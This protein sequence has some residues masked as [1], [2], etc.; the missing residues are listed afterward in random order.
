MRKQISA[1]AVCAVAVGLVA[2]PNA[3]AVKSDKM[4]FGTV[5]VGE[6]PNPVADSYQGT[7]AVTGNVASNSSCRKY[8]T[9]NFDWVIGA[10]PA[11]DA[12]PP[13]TITGPNGD[14]SA[15]LQRPPV[16]SATASSV[17]LRVTVDQAF[18]KIGGKKKSR[19]E[20]LKGRKFNCLT[21]GPADTTVNLVP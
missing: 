18:R 13:T 6:S 16:T 1:A 14:F 3:G 21:I 20:K 19:R 17:I 4:V 12:A 2:V 11:V 5:T 9:V 8:R 15:A 7:I 10:M